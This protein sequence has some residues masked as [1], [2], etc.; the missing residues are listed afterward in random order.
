MCQHITPEAPQ[1]N[2]DSAE[3]VNHSVSQG[4]EGVCMYPCL[5]DLCD[6]SGYHSRSPGG[7]S[8][9]SGVCE[10]VLAR[11]GKGYVCTHVCVTCVTSPFRHIIL[12]APQGNQ[13]SMEPDMGRE[14]GSWGCDRS[15]QKESSECV[16]W[17]L[18][19]VCDH[20]GQL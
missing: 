8:G 11:E 20:G 3:S 19:D 10:P 16:R 15:R 6:Q 17:C 13:D 9:C 14:R 1:G 5:C 4:R 18:W 2:L 12:E 7:K